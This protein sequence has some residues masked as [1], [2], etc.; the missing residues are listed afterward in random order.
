MDQHL[1][2]ALAMPILKTV[3]LGSLDG[4]GVLLPIR[5][6]SK[7]RLEIPRRRTAWSTC[8]F[9]AP[10]ESRR[11]NRI[12]GSRRRG[13][14]ASKPRRKKGNTSHPFLGINVKTHHERK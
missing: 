10:G 2:G 1:E 9:R 4:Y 13:N 12:T 5:Q 14:T 6:I 11:T 7:D 8:G 3:S